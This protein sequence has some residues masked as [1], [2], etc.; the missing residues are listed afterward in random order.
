MVKIVLPT[1]IISIFE[2]L[3]PTAVAQKIYNYKI[4]SLW[5][6]GKSA[7]IIKQMM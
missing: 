2:Y 7:E 3:P 5:F 1:S 4:E 6:I